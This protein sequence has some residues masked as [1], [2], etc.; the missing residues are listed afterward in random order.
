MAEEIIEQHRVKPSVTPR[1]IVFRYI[2]YLPWVIL[3][4]VVMLAA[5]Y[6][7]L[8]YSTPVYSVSGKLLV[9]S[10]PP[11]S[12]GGEKFDDIFMMQRTDRLNDEIEIIKSRSIASRVVRSLG[13]EMQVYNKGKIRSTIIHPNEVPFNFNVISTDSLKGFGLLV[14]L[15][16]NNQYRLNEDSTTYYFNQEVKLPGVVFKISPNDINRKSFASNEFLVS[17]TPTELRAVGLSGS[18]GVG[19]V[20]DGTNVLNISYQTENIRLGTDIVNRY[21]QEYQLASLEDKREIAGKTLAFINSQL[22]TVNRELK[23]V[24]N[25]LQNYRQQNKVFNPE[26]QTTLLFNE[27]S[28]SKRES[29][30]QEISIKAINNLISYLSNKQNSFNIISFTLGI[31]EPSLIE[32]VSA[33]NRL[34][35]ERETSLKTIPAN[36]PT[37]KAME[38]AIEKLRVDMI[39]NLKNVRQI[40]VLTLDEMNNQNRSAEGVISAIPAREKQ[41]LEVTR[42][43]AIL[44]ELYSYL[45]QK[46]LETAL[47]S[48]ST[49]SS[50]KVV[51]P[52]LSSGIPVSPKRNSLYVMAL[53]VGVAIPAGIIFLTGYLND[54]VKSKHEIQQITST[55]V[56]GE[57]GHADQATALVVTSN[58]RRFLAEQFR[59]VRSNLQYILPKVD[60]PAILVTS[61]FSGEGK[62]FISTNLGSVLA[63]SGKRTVI[64]EF[65]IRKPKIMKGLG[66]HERK[67]ITNYIVSSIKIEDV[68]HPV[69]DVENLYVVPCG[70]VPPNP[71]EM[72]LNERVSLLFQELRAKFDVIIVDTA[73][74]GLV[75]DAITLGQFVDAAVYIVRHNYTLKKQIHLIE[76]IYQNSKLPHLSIII[77]DIDA[78]SSYGGYGYGGYGYGYGYGLGKAK[79]GYFDNEGRGGKRSRLGKWFSVRKNK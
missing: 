11:Y 10:Q 30:K 17:W 49:I 62:S 12:G 29:F 26:A 42:Q 75:S 73:P 40:K 3:S 57:V 15:L 28:E 32:Q 50:I 23:G 1:E 48:A 65:D 24:E 39:E 18:I 68:V 79:N 9:S 69:S 7:K 56:L 6:L 46:K 41:M 33:F 74:V 36:N 51:E 8:R 76:D 2:R 37:I 45:L 64:L 60:K 44:Q 34:Q 63:L 31:E 59:V 13:L 58:S 78:T 47:A 72:L 43:Q 38:A 27:L 52:A 55:P 4:V 70:P 22:D 66:L 71:A 61:S 53:L 77:N 14:N 67:G 16:D 20:A 25:N 19:R 21:M 54:K 35:V 5:A